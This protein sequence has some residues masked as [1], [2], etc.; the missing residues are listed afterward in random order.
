ML[1]NLKRALGGFALANTT[2]VLACNTG[3]SPAYTPTSATAGTTPT[4]TPE[5][6]VVDLDAVPIVDLTTHSVPQEEVVFDTFDGRSVRLDM[7]SQQLIESLRDA[8]KPIYNPRYGDANGLPWLRDSD[9]VIGYKSESDA[10]AY[11][12][13]C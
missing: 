4:P 12:V 1:I 11:P 8:L 2:L 5:P 10:Y 6:I 9:L 3:V 7:A 13:R